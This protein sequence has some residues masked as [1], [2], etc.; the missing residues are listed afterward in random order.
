M[1]VGLAACGEDSVDPGSTDGLEVLSGTDTTSVSGQEFAVLVPG[2]SY[3][4]TASEPTD[5]LPDDVSGDAGGT[6]YVGLAW[7]P[8]GN[9]PEFG[10]VLH[11]TEA[12]PAPVRVQ[13]GDQTLDVT[14]LG[15]DVQGGNANG[16]V[17]VPVGDDTS[18]TL[19]VEYDGL[20]QTF[21]LTSGDREPGPADGFYEDTGTFPADCPDGPQ[22][23]GPWS[24]VVTC[25]VTDVAAVPY[26]AGAGWAEQG[27]T[28]LVLGVEVT[29]SALEWAEGGGRASYR[30]ATQDGGVS[31]DGVPATVLTEDSPLGDTWSASVAVPA[32][33]DAPV[34][35]T[36]ERTYQLARADGAAAAPATGEVTWSSSIDLPATTS[37]P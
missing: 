9:A 22:E 21:D 16:V 30:V 33:A 25:D 10:P 32:A 17:W 12:E 14:E 34:A 13:V 20:V 6:S 7:R 5:D 2:G 36:V 31:V 8:E 11:G 37:T 29:P 27:Q 23:T 19:E 3:V 24:Y 26:V 4:F 1:L 28:W 18:G 35:L 15:A